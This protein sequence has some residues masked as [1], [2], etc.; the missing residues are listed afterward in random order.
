MRKTHQFDK[1]PSSSAPPPQPSVTSLTVA[2]LR[3]KA[4]D[5]LIKLLM[6]PELPQSA[7][8]PIRQQVISIIQE[9]EGNEFVNRL[10]GLPSGR[11]HE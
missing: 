2:Q 5:D 4:T 3:G 7:N 8:D 9:R 10:L 1:E 6:S 11:E